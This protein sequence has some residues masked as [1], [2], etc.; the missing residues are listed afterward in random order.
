LKFLWISLGVLAFLLL[1]CLLTAYICFRMA[2]YSSRSK[3]KDPD[4]IPLPSGEIYEEYHKSMT[5][6]IR[7]MRQW[8]HETFEITS[9]DG[10]KLRGY[11]YEYKPGAP[12]ELM[13]HGY[14]SCAERDLCGGIRRCRR[15]GR[16]SLLVDQR[17]CGS[18]EGNVITFGVNEYRDCLAWL[19]FMVEHF[20]P[21]IKILLCGISMGAATVTIAA[22]KKLPDNV[23]GILADCGYTSAKDMILK[24]I[25]EMKLPPKLLYPFVKLGAR[26]YGKFDLEEISPM[27]AAK[28]CTVPAV[29]IHGEAD[30]FVPCE[31]SVK[32][33]E[34]CPARKAL[35]TVPGAGHGLSYPKAPEEYR[36]I[37]R[38]FFGPEA[39]APLMDDDPYF[40]Q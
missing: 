25:K 14:R 13:F 20:G 18:S 19:D 23:I 29:F 6:W 34:A 37:L 2:F 36:G 32:I 4:A 35:L 27:K 12:I 5:G 30:D 26:I 22:S 3:K 17:A 21:N 31:M 10:L 28:D 7:E 16:S 1:L 8:P 24:T 40:H 9:F 11:F 38:E 15:L 39:S 33:H